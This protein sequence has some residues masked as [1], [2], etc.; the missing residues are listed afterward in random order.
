M[1]HPIPIAIALTLAAALALS[2]LNGCTIEPIRTTENG[3][4]TTTYKVTP[5]PPPTT[6]A[7]TIP[8]A[9]IYG[10]WSLAYAALAL[11]T[12]SKTKSINGK[13]D[14]ISEKIDW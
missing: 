13:L 9:I 5:A 2:F 7:P 4:T 10:L 1:K 11:W 14:K 3:H 8:E 12:R 6:M